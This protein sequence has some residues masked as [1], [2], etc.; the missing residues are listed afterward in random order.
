MYVSQSVSVACPLTQHASLTH[1]PSS[2]TLH[3]INVT[4]PL[5]PRVISPH[6]P[7]THPSATQS[8]LHLPLHPITHMHP[9]V[10]HS[11]LRLPLHP[12]TSP[13]SQCYVFP[14]T[15][16][17]TIVTQLVLNLPLHP[18]THESTQSMYYVFPPNQRHTSPSMTA[19][20]R[21]QSHLHQ[22]NTDSE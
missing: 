6:Y 19:L 4:T 9:P 17:S 7:S 1:L 8:V 3:L 15:H 2:A 21:T 13:S 20:Y 18:S 5:P 11:G 14:Y 12:P 22:H 10:T 16:S